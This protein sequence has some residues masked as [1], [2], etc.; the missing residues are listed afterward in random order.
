MKLYLDGKKVE[1]YPGDTIIW[2]PE[3]VIEAY[4]GGICGQPIIHEAG[5]IGLDQE[6]NKIVS[7]NIINFS[8]IINKRRRFKVIG[9]KGGHK[10]FQLKAYNC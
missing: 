2:R 6:N 4:R 5:V 7:S 8:K 3:G 9:L 1:L 10:A